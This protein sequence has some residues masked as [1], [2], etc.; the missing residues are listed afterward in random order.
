[1]QLTQQN[2]NHLKK[3]FLI[4]F[5]TLINYLIH[6]LLFLQYD[7]LINGL[8]FASLYQAYQAKYLNI[9]AFYSQ[10]KLFKIL[11]YFHFHSQ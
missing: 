6:L 3:Y 10:L 11:I 8:F 4:H 5:L 2:S 9:Q 1:M 7:N